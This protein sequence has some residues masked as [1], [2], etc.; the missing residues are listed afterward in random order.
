VKDKA[1]PGKHRMLMQKLVAKAHQEAADEVDSEH[2]SRAAQ[3]VAE[4]YFRTMAKEGPASPQ[5]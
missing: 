5:K 1:D 4:E 3:K 2:A